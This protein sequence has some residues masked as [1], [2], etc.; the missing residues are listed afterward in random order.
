MLA[1]R[2]F[3]PL[4]GTFADH[5]GGRR[6]L[7]RGRRSGCCGVRGARQSG[8]FAAAQIGHGDQVARAAIAAGVGLGGLERSVGGRDAAVVQVRSTALRTPSQWALIVSARRLNGAS[9]QRRAQGTATCVV[10][11]QLLQRTRGTEA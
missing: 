8:G 6:Q 5:V 11:R 10:L 1:Y 3:G 2:P 4:F 9:L 7:S